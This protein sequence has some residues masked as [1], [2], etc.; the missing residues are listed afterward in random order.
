MS[1]ALKILVYGYG[2]PGRQDD[3]LG[4]ALSEAMERWARENKLKGIE[5]DANYQLNIEDAA[6]ISEFNL[7]I[8]ADATKEDIKDYAFT[9]LMPSPKI[10]FT[11]HSVSPA[12]IL[13]LCREVY[14]AIPSAFL[15]HIKGYAWEFMQDMTPEAK[16]NLEEATGFLKNKILEYKH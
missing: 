4:I 7:V 13:N 1:N 16:R 12:F 6:R 9:P 14:T 8:F 15:L 3:G 11:M 10:D 2:N 5:T